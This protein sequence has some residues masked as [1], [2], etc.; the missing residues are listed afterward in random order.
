MSQ[1]HPIATLLTQITKKVVEL[2][3]NADDQHWMFYGG[4][5]QGMQIVTDL[6][7]QDLAEEQGRTKA[8]K[9]SNAELL[10]KALISLAAPKRRVAERDEAGNIIASIEHP[11]V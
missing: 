3:K 2:S 10:E 5:L 1:D 6:W 4:V 9:A 7:K 8:T 11:L